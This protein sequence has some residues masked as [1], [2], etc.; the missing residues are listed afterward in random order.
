MDARYFVIAILTAASLLALPG[1]KQKADE[2]GGQAAMALPPDAAA[3]I[4]SLTRGMQPIAVASIS[5]SQHVG[6]RCVVVAKTP[7][8]RDPPPPPLGMVRL[9]GPTIVY[10]AQIHDVSADTLDVKAAYPNSD[11]VKIVTVPKADIQSVHLG[12]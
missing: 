2:A 3:T 9:L 5:K 10:I 7:E 1:C 8:R 4:Q 11:S 6:R 12:N